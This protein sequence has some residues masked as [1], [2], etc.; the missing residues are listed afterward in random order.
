MKFSKII[1]FQFFLHIIIQTN[2]AFAET[3]N[4]NPILVDFQ[5]GNIFYSGYY[6]HDNSGY[7]EYTFSGSVISMSFAY[8]FNQLEFH[9]GF[10][11]LIIFGMVKEE[12]YPVYSKTSG[13]KPWTGL[14]WYFYHP[15]FLN[16]KGGV[17]FWRNDVNQ[18]RGWNDSTE[19][20]LSLG[21]GY[22]PTLRKGFFPVFGFNCIITFPVDQKSPFSEFRNS[23]NNIIYLGQTVCG[24]SYVISTGLRFAF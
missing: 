11:H 6:T 4:M 3:K 9:A 20:L 21:I 24:L 14:Y 2:F 17:I 16:F 1:F 7:S 10:E 23:E 13:M 15:V 5:F 8:L 12:T 22:S 18:A 19:A